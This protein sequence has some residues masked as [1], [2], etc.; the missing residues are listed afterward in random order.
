MQEP[1]P[2][3]P[4]EALSDPTARNIQAIASLEQATL[5]RGSRLY[6]VIDAVTAAAGSP[7]FVLGHVAWFTLWMTTN[8]LR[9]LP[10]DP[11]PFSFLTLL[12]SLEAIILTGFVPMTQS[13]MTRQADKRTQLDLQINLLAEQE[14][15]AMLGMLHALCQKAGV[16]VKVRDARVEQLLKDTDIQQIADAIDRQLDRPAEP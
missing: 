1:R 6:R 15:T 11:F 5:H 8:L 9:D 3:A 14:L 7:L 10:F 4:A 16:T 2:E 13:R 12:V